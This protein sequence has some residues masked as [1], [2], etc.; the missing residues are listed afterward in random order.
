MILQNTYASKRAKFNAI[1]DFSE[2]APWAKD[3]RK[4][5]ELCD[6]QER[7]LRQHKTVHVP[8]Y[9]PNGGREPMVPKS[10]QQA[11]MAGTWGLEESGMNWTGEACRRHNN[12][13]YVG[14]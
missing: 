9:W 7:Y 5:S 2:A 11:V 1:K 14:K 10:W 12:W 13:Y 6:T 4:E 3:K 8:T